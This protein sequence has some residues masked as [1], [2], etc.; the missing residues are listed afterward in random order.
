MLDEGVVGG[1]QGALRK[2][3]RLLEAVDFGC[4]PPAPLRVVEFDQKALERTVE[5]C[6]VVEYWTGFRYTDV[7]GL[8]AV[9]M[10][11]L[12]SFS[13]TPTAAQRQSLIEVM[14]VGG[15]GC[16]DKVG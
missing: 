10:E 8:R 3:L 12:N 16:E 7:R 1:E 2:V 11:E 14:V 9:L 13:G 6:E 4:P 15:R 5:S